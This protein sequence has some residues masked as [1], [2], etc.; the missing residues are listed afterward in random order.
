MDPDPG[1]YSVILASFPDFLVNFGPMILVIL[2]LLIFSAIVS[3]TEVA[4][5]SLSQA[6]REE[7]KEEGGRV[8]ELLS[9]PKK[10]LA[11]ILIFN[12][13]VNVAIILI[14][15]FFIDK[16]ARHYNWYGEGWA[17][18]V[19]PIVEVGLITFVLLFFGEITPK[20]YATQ[21]R[22]AIVRRVSMPIFVSRSLFSPLSWLLIS[23]TSFLDRRINAQSEAA[24]FEDLKHAIDLTSEEESPDEEKEI[25]KGIVNF[26]NT[27][28]KAIMRARVDIV[29]IELTTPL[30]DIVDL[31]QDQG[32][33]RMPVYEESLDDVKGILYV[34][35]LLPLLKEDSEQTQWVQLIRPAYFIP[36]TKK[37]DDLLDEFKSKRLHIAMV[38]DEFGGTSGLVTLED[39]IEEIFGEITDEFDEEELVFSKLSETTYIFDGKMPLNDILRLLEVPGNSFDEVRGDA[40][41]L[42]GLIL[43]IHGRLPVRGDVVNHDQFKFSIE[44]VTQRRIKRVKFE[45]LE[46]VQENVGQ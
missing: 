12:N 24:S 8:W 19:L 21:N 15:S 25:L 11:T 10:L 40:D 42:A 9:K 35:D 17:D 13:L 41:T 34:K 22:L 26:A 23:S 44:S 30:S 33:S 6:E 29:A 45:V 37:I 28:V 32:Y 7:F 31:I 14:S 39:I 18:I 1:S 36:E 5:F 38:V 27:Q 16:M 4:Y 2:V 43:E 3:G 46:D 20:V